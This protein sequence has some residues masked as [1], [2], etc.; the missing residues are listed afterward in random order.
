MPSAH[1]RVG[2]RFMAQSS[3]DHRALKLL[4]EREDRLERRRARKN[5]FIQAVSDAT[6]F[7]QVSTTMYAPPSPP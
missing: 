5:L 3:G 2:P 6:D 7:Q 4:R 1:S